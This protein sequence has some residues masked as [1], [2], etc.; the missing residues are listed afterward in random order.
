MKH[1]PLP[2]HQYLGVVFTVIAFS[3]PFTVFT[4]PLLFF[5]CVLGR[6]VLHW[7]VVRG[8]AAHAPPGPMS[9]EAKR[10][11][12]LV[13]WLLGLSLS[14]ISVGPVM[15]KGGVLKL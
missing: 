1:L 14:A 15:L 11:L 13:A 9:A 6:W 4:W 3:V 5:S 10:R 7:F 12:W 8:F 2:I